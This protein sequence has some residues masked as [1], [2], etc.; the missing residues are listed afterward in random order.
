MATLGLERRFLFQGHL[1]EFRAERK[2]S[3]LYMARAREAGHGNIMQ[4]IGR[5]SGCGERETCE[6]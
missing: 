2:A 5:S 4:V 6:L 3:R 1:E